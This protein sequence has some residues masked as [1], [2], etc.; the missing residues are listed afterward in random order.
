MNPQSE[1]D[2]ENIVAGSVYGGLGF[3]LEDGKVT[4]MFLGAM[5]E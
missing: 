1:P 5:A 2:P 3:T 4:E